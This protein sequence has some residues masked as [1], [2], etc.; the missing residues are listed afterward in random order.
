VDGALALR[1]DAC[2]GVGSFPSCASKRFFAS[3]YCYSA[4]SFAEG[5]AFALSGDACLG[6][7][8]A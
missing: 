2:L 6:V 7:Y 5:V 1:G 4:V 3:S 8:G